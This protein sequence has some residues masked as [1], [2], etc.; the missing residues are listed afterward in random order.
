MVAI[1]LGVIVSGFL[2]FPKTR[3]AR[4][5]LLASLGTTNQGVLLSPVV[6]IDSLNLRSSDG[7][8]WRLGQQP[9]KWRL[10]IP[11]GRHCGTNCKNILYT[12]RQMHVRLGKN[13]HRLQ[14]VYLSLDG[15][16]DQQTAEFF[17][18]EH[19]YLKVLKGDAGEFTTWVAGTNAPWQAGMATPWDTDDEQGTMRALV[20]DQKGNAMLFYQGKHS[21]N[22]MLDDFNHLFKYSAE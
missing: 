12:T 18:T 9:R 22:Q 17:K 14:R 20:V 19:P 3:E 2:V 8:T 15:E 5:Q 1:V 11:G 4:N 7:A 6:P 10:L 21:G 16:P 13:S